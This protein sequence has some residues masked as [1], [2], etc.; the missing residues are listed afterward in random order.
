MILKIKYNEDDEPTEIRQIV[1]ISIDDDQKYA[2]TDEDENPYY[3]IESEPRTIY[4]HT[5]FEDENGEDS[6]QNTDRKFITIEV[7][8]DNM[9]LIKK[10]GK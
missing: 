5:V 2:I 8:T 1:G 10:W 6:F 7:L 4:R 9:V 3:E